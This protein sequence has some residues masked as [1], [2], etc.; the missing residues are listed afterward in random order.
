M[1]TMGCAVVCMRRI[2]LL[3][4]NVPVQ[5]CVRVSGF[6]G[7]L[8]TTGGI[9]NS[10]DGQTCGGCQKPFYQGSFLHCDSDEFATV[11]SCGSGWE[12][13]DECVFPQSREI[14]KPEECRVLCERDARCYF[15]TTN[16]CCCTLHFTTQCTLQ[17]SSGRTVHQV[18]GVF[19]T[20]Q[21][22]GTL[23]FRLFGGIA[24]CGPATPYVVFV[25]GGELSRRHLPPPS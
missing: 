13:T 21:R 18:R 11:T 7:V 8:N 4:H 19:R 10:V 12:E 1:A 25:V 24:S 20:I 22:K 6:A 5:N 3:M 23:F 9:H 16:W 15:Y 17:S 14:W 2:C